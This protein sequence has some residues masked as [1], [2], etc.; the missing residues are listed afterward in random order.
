[1]L[2]NPCVSFQD[3]DISPGGL[4]LALSETGKQH[5][6]MF[7]TLAAAFP[8]DLLSPPRPLRLHEGWCS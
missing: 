3:E 1:M 6:L 5:T 4:G 7:I 2:R 8:A